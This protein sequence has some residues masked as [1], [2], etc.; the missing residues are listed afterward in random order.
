MYGCHIYW[1]LLYILG[2][3]RDPS[4]CRASHVHL[5]TSGETTV[6]D[7]FEESRR[8]RD[9]DTQ[10]SHTYTWAQKKLGDKPFSIL[11]LTDFFHCVL[12][13]NVAFVRVQCRS[14]AGIPEDSKLSVYSISALITENMGKNYFQSAHCHALLV[15]NSKMDTS[16][17][18]N[19]FYWSTDSNRFPRVRIWVAMVISFPG[20]RACLL[21]SWDDYPAILMVRSRHLG[22][23]NMAA[24]TFNWTD[25]E[26]ELLLKLTNEYKVKNENENID[27]SSE[28]TLI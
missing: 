16:I 10:L 8:E 1:N 28:N 3:S 9:T 20:A 21:G 18:L 2:G 26:V 4:S 5:K 12:L 27:W 22:F 15:P 17:V 23:L 6:R 7:N 11:S 24:E 19:F 13:G 14:T 25:D